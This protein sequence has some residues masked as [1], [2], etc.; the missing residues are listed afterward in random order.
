MATGRSGVAH[1]LTH[2]PFMVFAVTQAVSLFGDKLD[3]MALLALFAWFS[4][5]L[6]VDSSRAISALSVVAAL[7]TILCAPV[8]GVIVDR[9]DRRRLMLACDA[10][11]AVLV[12]LVPVVAVGTGALGPV[13]VVAFFVFLSGH[14]FQSARM[15]IIPQLVDADAPP[16]PHLPGP[17]DPGQGPRRLLAANSF[18]NLIGRVATL[19]GMV[20]GGLIVDWSGW[21]RCG[22][23]PSWSAGFYIDGLSYVVSVAGLVLVYRRLGGF[24]PPPRPDAGPQTFL[25]AIIRRAAH[26]WSDIH[27]AWRF[28]VRTPPVLFVYGSVM[29]LVT[30]GAAFLILYIPII[31]GS[32]ETATLQMGTRGVGYFAAIGSVGLILSSVGYGLIGHHV[33]RETVIIACCATLGGIAAVLPF[34]HHF[35]LVAPLAFIG[36][37]AMTPIYIAMDT[38]LHESVPADTRGRVFSNREWVMHL[39]FALNALVIGQLTRFV[40]NRRLL[41]AVGVLVLAA[42]AGGLFALARVRRWYAANGR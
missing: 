22:I 16:D 28:A 1:V 23:R 37:L 29:T 40:D 7:P 2:R 18:M 11:R 41:F 14:L 19:A 20:L 3:Y 35:G 27:E 8:A 24:L 10:A 33:R 21:A 42:S 32:T 4:A 9:L 34:V 39:A 31:Q 13:F 6:G 15:S 36:G 12:G 25:N 5:T 38:I 17:V 26:T 30:A